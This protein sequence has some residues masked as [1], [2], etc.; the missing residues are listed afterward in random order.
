M[1]YENG[2]DVEYT[3]EFRVKWKLKRAVQLAFEQLSKLLQMTLKFLSDYSRKSPKA[4]TICLSN[5]L[6]VE[7]DAT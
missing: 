1:E 3:A 4:L 5:K 2:F 6:K 7:A